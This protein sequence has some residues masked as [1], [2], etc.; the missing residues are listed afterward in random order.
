MSLSLCIED[1]YETFGSY[2]QEIDPFSSRLWDSNKKTRLTE[3]PNAQR[4]PR[5]PVPLLAQTHLNSENVFFPL[6]LR[7]ALGVH[8]AVAHLLSDTLTPLTR[9]TSVQILYTMLWTYGQVLHSV[10]RE[11]GQLGTCFKTT[12]L[13]DLQDDRSSLLRL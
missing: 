7:V 11:T 3:K 1:V 10:L 2:P 8:Y 12:L 6:F 9:P 5:G 13:F 4:S